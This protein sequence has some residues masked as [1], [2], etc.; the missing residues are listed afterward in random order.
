MIIFFLF[1]MET[2]CCDPSS[3]LSR[4]DSSKEGSQISFYAALMKITPNYHQAL[5]YLEL[6]GDVGNVL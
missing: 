4:R 1:L 5:P 3:E 6:C 2:I